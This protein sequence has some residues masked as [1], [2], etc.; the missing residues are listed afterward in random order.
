MTNATT[1]YTA[2]KN[3]WQNE[4]MSEKELQLLFIIENWTKLNAK[5]RARIAGDV[6]RAGAKAS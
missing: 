2:W 5:A 3:T 4:E 6:W 1:Q